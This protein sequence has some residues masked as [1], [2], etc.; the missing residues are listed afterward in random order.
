MRIV[1]T[2]VLLVGLAF[3]ATKKKEDEIYLVK[4]TPDI[5]Y[6]Y[7]DHK[8]VKVKVMRIQD[9]N[10][11]LTDDYSKTSRPC[12]PFCIHPIKVDKRVKTVATVEVVKFMRDK[13]N[14]GKGIIIDARLPKWY[15]AETIPS[16]INVPFTFLESNPPKEKVVA[17]F[18][19][20]GAK[21]KNGKLD[22]SNAKELLIFCNGVWCD[23]SPRLIR[24]L[25]KYGYPTDKILYYR[26]GM[27]GWKLLGLTTVVEKGNFIKNSQTK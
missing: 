2:L 25:I 21:E 18:K 27:Q 3:G 4:I 10:H 22:F 24:N 6:V 9:T 20:L 19:L 12:P 8:G 13:V 26:N 7:V 1:V 11:L 17:F 14:S 16:A 15:Y 5:P 23:Q